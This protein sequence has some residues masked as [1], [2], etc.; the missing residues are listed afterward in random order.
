[1]QGAAD[2]G[3]HIA[4]SVTKHTNRVFHHPTAFHTAVHMFNPYASARQCL[5][6][7]LLFIRERTSTWFLE[8]CGATHASERKGQK[9][10]IL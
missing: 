9:P 6:K 8:W 5:V 7:R 10:Q 3:D 2:F 1:M 4:R